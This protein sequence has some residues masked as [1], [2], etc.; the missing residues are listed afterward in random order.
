[1]SPNDPTLQENQAAEP[2]VRTDDNSRPASNSSENERAP[3]PIAESRPAETGSPPQVADADVPAP[4]SSGDQAGA[5]A[6][7]ASPATES[8]TEIVATTTPPTVIATTEE[9]PAS[10]S[11]TAGPVGVSAENPGPETS[12]AANAGGQE[13]TVDTSAAETPATPAPAGEIDG[14]PESSV[15]ESPVAVAP[16]SDSGDST[17]SETNTTGEQTSGEVPAKPRVTLDRT[18][19]EAEA[20]GAAEAAMQSLAGQGAPAGK[21]E[22]PRSAELDPAMEQELE[23]ALSGPTG[24]ATD[25][26]IPGEPGSTTTELIDIESLEA[27]SRLKGTVHVVTAE[28]IFVDLGLRS[29]GMMP[30]RQLPDGKTLEAGQEIEVIVDKVDVSAG[31]LTVTLPH[32][33]RK[34]AGNWDAVTKGQIVDAMVTKTNK[35]GLE[36]TVSHLRGFLPASQVDMGFVEDLET[37]VGQKVTC[38][39][40]EV[41]PQKRNLVLSRRAYLHQERR[42][43]EKE[44]WQSLE[45][46][47]NH[48]GT[49]KTIKNYGAFVDVGGVDGFLHVGD[50]SWNR[51]SHPSDILVV[52]QS[53]EVTILKLDPESRKIGLGMKQLQDNPWS[54]V[55]ERYPLGATVNGKVTRCTEFGAFI[56][57]EEGVEGLIHI[58]ELDHRRVGRVTEVVNVG[59]EVDVKVLAVEPKRRRIGLSLKALKDKPE[60]AKSDVPEKPAYE[61]KHKGP[62][63]G[64]REG[65][66][67]GAAGLFGNPDDFR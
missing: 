27:G 3:Q 26:A 36:V 37:F 4:S 5:E 44:L 61:R 14:E 29:P 57:L 65:Q 19:T 6:V 10:D 20:E 40:T 33:K 64:G 17:T 50:I 49:V 24:A 47:Q 67:G 53:I 51:I 22:I 38:V 15:S 58:S 11:E 55:Q 63:R 41:N 28:T 31:T 12:D 45:K 56:A 9:I 21:I 7:S 66:E 35:G 16:T 46:G 62:L 34:A 30:T 39:I 52:G 59:D 23:R 43:K 32:A 48:T 42:E 18:A 54:N 8:M 1:M 60:P 2:S 25:E 13:T